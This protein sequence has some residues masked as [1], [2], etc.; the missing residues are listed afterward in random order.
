[1][2]GII[3]DRETVRL[4]LRQMDGGGVDLRARHRLRRRVYVS[5]GP[6]YVWHI[7][8]WKLNWTNDLSMKLS[9]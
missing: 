6:K 3:T 9:S 1:M 8:G 4:F 7:D 5:R 2:A